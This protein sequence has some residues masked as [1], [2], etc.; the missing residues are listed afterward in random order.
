MHKDNRRGIVAMLVAMA[1][2]TGSDAFVKLAR[3]ALPTGELIALRGILSAVLALAIL[4]ARGDGPKLPLAWSRLTAV[5]AGIEVLA[6]LCY[7]GAI[8]LI[9]LAELIAISQSNPLITLVLCAI[10]GL[11]VVGW[12]R[13]VAV[14]VGFLG[15]LLVVRPGPAT[16]QPGAL[17][18]LAAALLISARDLVNRRIPDAVPTSVILFATA[19]AV[20]GGGFALGLVEHWVVPAAKDAIDLVAAGVLVT[21]GHLAMIMAFRGTTIA[22]VSPFRYSVILWGIVVGLLV[23]A[24]VPDL[25][26]LAGAALI[27][28]SGIYTIHRERGIARPAARPALEGT[29]D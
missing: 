11:E 18:A 2:F 23:F 13:T 17:L 4:L 7:V 8:A 25:Y 26:T 19:V 24:E 12:R 28:A 5:R 27:V 29:E 3:E 22:V 15:L 16:F 14:L 21:A 9:P 10:L 20:A 6:T 1:A